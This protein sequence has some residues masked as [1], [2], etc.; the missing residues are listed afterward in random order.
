[1]GHPANQIIPSGSSLYSNLKRSLLSFLSMPLAMRD[2]S[3]DSAGNQKQHRPAATHTSNSLI[4]IHLESQTSKHLLMLRPGATEDK[5]HSYIHGTYSLVRERD[6][7][8]SAK[9]NCDK[10]V[11]GKTFYKNAHKNPKLSWQSGKT[12]LRK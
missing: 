7:K 8:Y 10:C 9:Y 12:S 1:M 2:S 5:Q 3:L 11:K 4:N 6:I